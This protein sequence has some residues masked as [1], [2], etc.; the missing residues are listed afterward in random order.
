MKKPMT[1][2]EFSRKGGLSKS[3]KKSEASRKN[4]LKAVE[5]RKRN[6]A[7]RRSQSKD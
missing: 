4:Q 1:M 3:T 2:T 6:A 5:A 7:A